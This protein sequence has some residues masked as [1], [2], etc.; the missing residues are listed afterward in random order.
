[1]STGLGP[2]RLVRRGCA[3]QFSG[4][5]AGDPRV[6]ASVDLENCIR[7]SVHA[8]NAWALTSAPTDEPGALEGLK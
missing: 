1:M 7:P 2:R 6:V 8:F 3:A 5:P 4:T